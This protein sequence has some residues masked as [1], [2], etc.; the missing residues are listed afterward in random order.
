MD[1]VPVNIFSDLTPTAAKTHDFYQTTIGVYDMAA[2]AYGYSMVAGERAG[3]KHG[4]L[5]RLALSAPLFLTD[6]DADMSTNPY[7]QRFDLS[8]DPIDYANDR[9]ELVRTFRTGSV[10]ASKVAEDASWA[11]LWRYEHMMLRMINT[12]IETLQPFLGGVDAT[13][14]HRKPGETTYA[15]PL[16][17]RD[18]QLRALR[19]LSRIIRADDGVFPKPADYASYIQIQGYDHED[20]GSPSNDYGCL[21]RGLV[22]VDEIIRSIR[23]KAVRAALFPALE[24]IVA[25]DVN[26][27]LSIREV[28]SAVNAATLSKSSEPRN[29]VVHAYFRDG[30]RLVLKKEEEDSRIL[31]E[32]SAF[33]NATATD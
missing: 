33:L 12:T 6:E 14:A 2:I 19:V 10:L 11:T 32:I 31:R 21:A 28:L 25:Q 17:P 23:E 26:S 20:C 18:T 3:Y 22:D 13:H 8:S 4:M 30:L 29:Q 27:P 15:V 7:A 16:I 24:R 1:Y 9:L 5:S